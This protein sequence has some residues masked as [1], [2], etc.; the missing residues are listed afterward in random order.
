MIRIYSYIFLDFLI[1]VAANKD[2]FNQLIVNMKHPN[3]SRKLSVRRNILSKEN[4]NVPYEDCVTENTST[5]R[6]DEQSN[7]L[8]N[9]YIEDSNS[10]A[11]CS[12]INP[13]DFLTME[14]SA[15][16]NDSNDP[17]NECASNYISNHSCKTKSVLSNS[18]LTIENAKSEELLFPENTIVHEEI[19]SSNQSRE[20]NASE[21]RM[22]V[23]NKESV[24]ELG[25]K[26]E[27]ER[28]ATFKRSYDDKH[29]AYSKS[30][31]L[32][33]LW[34]KKKSHNEEIN[35]I[36]EDIEYVMRDSDDSDIQDYGK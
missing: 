31:D 29:L 2:S 28:K 21:N 9:S 17:M 4:T 14:L 3:S 19:I 30:K 1:S 22:D 32:W 34:K 8:A 27:N 16:S 18:I 13:I 35:S 10:N 24:F 11:S 33:K 7:V 20:C 23:D 6:D 12:N 36:A 25:I 5:I 26:S 15:S